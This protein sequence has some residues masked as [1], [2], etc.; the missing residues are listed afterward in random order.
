MY[1]FSP[2]TA[3]RLN[4]LANARQECEICLSALSRMERLD[5][6]RAPFTNQ[7]K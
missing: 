2:T 5:R 6:G 1:A 7:P 3:K 4:R